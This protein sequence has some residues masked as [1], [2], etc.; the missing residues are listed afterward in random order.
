M[1]CM[2]FFDDRPAPE[3]EPRMHHPWD[4]PEAELPGIVQINTVLLGQTDRSA[5]AVT[6]L[7]AYSTG[8]EIFLTARFRPPR[9]GGPAE[10]S[11][12]E[13]PEPRAT[14]RSLRFGLQLS[15]GR[16]AIGEHAGRGPGSDTAPDG[17]ILR[18]FMGGGGPR[19]IVIRWWAWPLPPLARWSSS[20]N[21]PPSGFRKRGRASTRS[22][23][24]T[25]RPA[26]SRCGQPGRTD[27]GPRPAGWP[28]TAA[29]SMRRPASQPGLANSAPACAPA[30][31]RPFAELGA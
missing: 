18:E 29:G 7:S 2:G 25:R 19:S 17:P 11:R 31:K 9:G 8:F 6:G 24:W 12:A 28:A 20:A 10:P 23:S 16:K 1:A 30:E 21:G 13:P 27:G 14:R 5:V 4:P 22:P 26:A 3:P 15:D